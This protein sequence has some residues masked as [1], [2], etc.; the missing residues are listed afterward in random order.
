[1][2][3]LFMKFGPFS[4]FG[5]TIGPHEIHWYGVLITIGFLLG[6]ALAMRE[7]KR[8][9]FNPDDILDFSF[10]VLLAGLIG[11]R[12]VFDVV[13][14]KMYYDACYN[15]AVLGLDAPDCTRV[16]RFWEGGLVWYGGLLGAFPVAY[17]YLRR[18]K[19]PFFK[20]ADVVIPSVSLG[21]A[22][23]RLGCY[24]AGC[25][26]GRPTDSPLG[27]SF[28]PDS[29]AAQAQAS[30]ASLNEI[31][32]HYTGSIPIHPTQL[33]ESFGEFAIFLFLVFARRRKRFHGQLFLTYLILY[34]LLRT[35]V[36]LFRGDHARGY[37]IKWTTT[38]TFNGKTIIDE[39]GLS[40][41]EIISAAV[42]LSALITIFIIIKKRK[43]RACG[44]PSESAS[45]DGNKTAQ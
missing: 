10:W 45:T 3:P 41:S 27:V 12:V 25:C 13:N 9:N 11:S 32:S 42:A 21:H 34:P 39:N 15:P 4:V 19:M 33:Y 1:M 29:M 26:F 2:F 20:T 38:Q 28:P 35:V 7:G 18:K 24:A 30:S 37:L 40:T 36:E 43:S 5:W 17:W 22:F 6:V 23:G 44:T 8:N 31:A 16:F 14:W